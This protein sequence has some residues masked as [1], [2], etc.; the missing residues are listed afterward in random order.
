MLAI[1]YNALQ[2]PHNPPRGWLT[3]ADR[4]RTRRC[5][6]RRAS[7]RCRRRALRTQLVP[8]RRRGVTRQ[9]EKRLGPNADRHREHRRDGQAGGER[10]SG[11]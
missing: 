2:I 7:H 6:P 8:D 11:R 10:R 4:P 3:A 5:I 9:L 1:Q